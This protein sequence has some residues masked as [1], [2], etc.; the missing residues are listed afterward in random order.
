MIEASIARSAPRR[1]IAGRI[2][3]PQGRRDL[4]RGCGT[5]PRCPSSCSSPSLKLPPRRVDWSTFRFL[6]RRSRPAIPNGVSG[7][8]CSRPMPGRVP[9]HHKR[10]GA[11]DQFHAAV[12]ALIEAGIPAADI[13]SLA[14]LVAPENFK[15][16]SPSLRN[17]RGRRKRLQQGVARSLIEI[18][19]QWVKV[20]EATAAELRR[21]AENC[22]LLRPD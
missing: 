20:D 16:I 21:S 19:Y 6:P 17:E 22:C 14:D 5:L 7:P 18:A 8:T 3:A 11:P 1:C 9:W 2:P 12:S 10:F 4:E 15:R 13:T